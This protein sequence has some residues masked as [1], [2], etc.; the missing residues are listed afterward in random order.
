MNDASDPDGV[1]GWLLASA[2]YAAPDELP[3]LVT[4]AA[5]SQ[6]VTAVGIYLIDHQQAVLQPLDLPQDAGEEI[7]DVDTTLPGRTYR[8]LEALTSSDSDHRRLWVPL[9]DGAARLGVLRFDFPAGASLEGWP[10]AFADALAALTAALVIS[11]GAYGDVFELVRRRRNVTLPAE[12]QHNLLPPLTAATR[13]AVIAGALEPAYEV[14]GDAFDYAIDGD[15]VHWVMVDAMGHGLEAALLASV[16]LASHRFARRN[17]AG[18]GT[19][20]TQID[21]AVAR[22]FGGEKFLTGLLGS[23]DRR[24]GEVRVLAAGHPPPLLVR[25]GHVVREIDVGE[26]ALP[27]GLNEGH[28]IAGLAEEALEPGDR[29][30][31]YSDGVVEARSPAGALFGLDRLGDLVERELA[32]EQTAA[33][34]MRR[35]MRAVLDHQQA[36]LQDDATLLFLEW[37]GR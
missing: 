23:L 10:T 29:I 27:L 22:Q 4:R 21:T 1:L 12:I 17:H 13:D 2:R 19:T 28:P 5:V 3:E 34:A 36:H 11:K 30:L 7:F 25:G 18:L 6:G 24:T 31:A 37:L 15:V 9:L 33:E 35:L 20:L 8:T 26:P 14:A 16:A 32:A